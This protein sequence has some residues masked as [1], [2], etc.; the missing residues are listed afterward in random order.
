MEKPWVY[1]VSEIVKQ[2]DSDL[3]RGLTEKEAN[4]RLVH[5]GYNKLAEKKK[6]HPIFLFLGQFRSLIIWVLIIAAIIAGFLKEWIDTFAIIG[7][8]I[9]NSILGFIQEFKAEKALDALKKLFTQY[10]KVLREGQLR[11]VPSEFL[12]PGD[13]IELE[14]GDNIPADCRVIWHTAN[15][16]V[17]EASLTG[18]STPVVKTSI[19]LNEPETI[20]AERANMAY[21]GTSVSSGRARCIVVDTGMRTELG[22]ITEMIEEASHEKTPLQTRLENFGKFLVYICLFL[23]A[24]IFLVEWIRGGTFIDVFLTAVSLAV[25]AIPEGLPAVV[26]IGLALG[27]QRMARRNVLI[28]KL[29]SVET[30]GCATTICSDKTGTLTKNEMT[31]K[32]IYADGNIISV[33]GTGYNPEGNLL[34]NERTVIVE[35]FS[36]LD[37]ALLCAVVCNT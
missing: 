14:A 18:E 37:K 16:T 30:L 23:V 8:V 34:I 3:S 11:V 21:M 13:I 19:P 6:R 4:K 31:V 1:E 22:K 12:V 28:R 25:A 24:L 15:F 26:T 7:I 9:L 32:K 2:L 17:Q 36:G 35:Q 29:P 5:Y 20:I 33:T 10:S 27:V